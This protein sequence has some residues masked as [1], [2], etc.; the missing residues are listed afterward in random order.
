MKYEICKMSAA[1]CAA[2]QRT[3]GGG[4]N[5]NMPFVVRGT[6]GQ[7]CLFDFMQFAAINA[8]A[9]RRYEYLGEM[10]FKDVAAMMA[11]VDAMTI[12]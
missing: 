8:D 9:Q 10:K 5:G 4:E 6:P 1:E 2:L 11:A 3:I 7:L 12:E